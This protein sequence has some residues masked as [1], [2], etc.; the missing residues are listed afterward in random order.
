MYEIVFINERGKRVSLK[1][2][3]YYLYEKTLNKLKH[4]KACVLVSW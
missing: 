1:F 4:S 3:S 2:E